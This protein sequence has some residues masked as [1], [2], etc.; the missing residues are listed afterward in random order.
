MISKAG[1]NTK[2]QELVT[3]NGHSN[4]DNDLNPRHKNKYPPTTNKQT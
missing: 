1:E 3:A 4:R 2:P